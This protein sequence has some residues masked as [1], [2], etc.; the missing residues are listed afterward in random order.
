MVWDKKLLDQTIFD[1]IHGHTLNIVGGK[2]YAFGGTSGACGQFYKQMLVIDCDTH[3]IEV[4]EDFNGEQPIERAYHRS[5]IYGSKILFYGGFNLKK[6]LNDYFTFNSGTNK[7]ISQLYNNK[8]YNY[9]SP[10]G[11]IVQFVLKAISS[12]KGISDVLQI[13]KYTGTVRRVLRVSGFRI[14]E[15]V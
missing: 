4:F 15:R 10:K 3:N 12:R 9:P 2:G 13:A 14:R 11:E 7:S 5:V 8:C 1:K 6:V